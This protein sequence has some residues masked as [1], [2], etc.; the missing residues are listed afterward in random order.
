MEEFNARARE[1]VFKYRADW[2]TLCERIGYWLD[3]E[4][5]YVTY[6]NDYVES[7]WW[8]LQTLHAAGPAL[9]RAQVLPYC[10]RCGTALSSH[11]VAQGYEDVNDQLGLRH[12]P[13]G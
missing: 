12:L 6:D 10:P 11:E 9:P 3:Y 13:G 8:A 2:E 5:P 7:V 4:H 1:S